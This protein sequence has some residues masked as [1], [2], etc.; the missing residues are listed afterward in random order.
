MGGDRDVHDA[1]AIMGQ[2]HQDEQ[3][4]ARHGRDHEEVGRG[5]LCPVIRQ[6]GAPRLRRRLA[7]SPDDRHPDTLI[8]WHR[9][10]FRLFRK[11]K[12]KRPGRRPIPAD[13]RQFIAEM[14]TANRTWGRIAAE[15]LVK[16][17]IRVSRTVTRYLRGRRHARERLAGLEHVRAQPR[18]VRTGV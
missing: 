8:R 11:W 1:S 7:R 13:L 14:A 6:E 5:D 3:E 18:A 17:G 16:L 4:A 12:S 15:L 9:Q 2:H 10:G